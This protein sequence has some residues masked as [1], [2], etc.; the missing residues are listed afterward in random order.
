MIMRAAI[1]FFLIFALT[2]YVL[3]AFGGERE[4]RLGLISDNPDS[5]IRE[6]MPLMK[7]V[8]A[9]LK[10]FNIKDARIVV[11]KDVDEMLKK[12]ER[13]EVDIIFE[14]AFSTIEMQEKAGIMPTMLVWRK[15]VREYRTVFF[16]RRESPIKSLSDLKGKT[17]VFEDQKS[18]SAYA[19]PKAELKRRGLTVLPLNEKREIKD[20]VRYIFTGEELNQA[21]FVVQK[22]ADAGAFNNND[23]DETSEKVRADLRIIH[24]TEPMPRYMASFHPA[25]PEKLR[26]AIKNI[27]EEL[28]KTPEGKEILKKA[29]RITKIERLTD[30]DL[31]A[32]KYL[33][34]LMEFIE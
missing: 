34:E 19:M 2:L 20:A 24:E 27:F 4:L 26:K 28:H 22:R 11:A 1:K 16:V 23:W 6:Y 21:F 12:I 32:L 9:R 17:I 13:G 31:K 3:P 8:A 10:E 14:S 5:R 25:L 7:N 30:A 33:K 15:G 29:S 18:T